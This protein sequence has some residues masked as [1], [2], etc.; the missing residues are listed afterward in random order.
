M[1]EG[2]D[3]ENTSSLVISAITTSVLQTED[4][5]ENVTENDSVSIN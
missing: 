1:A 4:I 5:T 3:T 2:I